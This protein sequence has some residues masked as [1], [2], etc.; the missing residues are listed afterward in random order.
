MAEP[1]LR[2]LERVFLALG[3]KTRLRLLSLMADG[4]V[5]V[6]FLVDNLGESQPKVSRHLAYL[7]GAGVVGTRR[8]GKWIYYYISCPEEL[9]QIVDMAVR[10]V[11]PTSPKR[12]GVRRRPTVIPDEPVED[13]IYEE[14]DILND[15]EE[16]EEFEIF[17]TSHETDD[18][19]QEMEIFLL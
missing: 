3:D 6:G 15:P 14:A 10:S 11:N 17:E 19:P 13:N 2:Q 1:D 5:P 18:A 4:E 16:I 12:K 8:D 7:R 9:S